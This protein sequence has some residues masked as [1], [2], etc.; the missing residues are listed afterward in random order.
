MLLFCILSH[1]VV[2]A[3]GVPSP[4]LLLASLLT[5]LSYMLMHADEQD[6]DRDQGTGQSAA[7]QRQDRAAVA[8]TEGPG[9]CAAER[10]PHESGRRVFVCVLA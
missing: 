8:E 2:F 10:S 1:K 5:T 4:L 6:Q 3:L 9:E 7:F